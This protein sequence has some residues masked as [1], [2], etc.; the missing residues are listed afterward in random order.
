MNL[1]LFTFLLRRPFFK[2]Q[3]RIFNYLFKKG[4]LESF[5]NRI[6]KPLVGNFKIKC[7]TKTW[8]GAQIIYLGE[9]EDYIKKTFAT[10]IKQEDI[11]LD[12][13]ANIGFHTLYFASLVGENGKVIA[14]EPI[15]S[16]FA[17][18]EENV[19]LNN[20][21]NIVL[22]NLALGNENAT[23][24]INIEENN[25]NPG[26]NNLFNE[27][28]TLVH[29]KIGDDIV[30][31]EKVNFIKIDVEGYELLALKGLSEL[32]RKQKP[33]IIFEYD[34]NYQLKTSNNPLDIFSFIESFEYTFH[35][36]ERSGIKGIKNLSELTSADILALPIK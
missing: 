32:I 22:H 35:T 1:N 16:T 13:G 6:V 21:N 31:D 24:G 26:A 29:C 12:I 36:I 18:L 15:P 7:N 9:Y 23:L 19:G 8:I 20:F 14:F 5:E 2:G 30:V 3:H 28:N 4:Y 34:K 17:L 11:V 33:T 10:Y 25:I 27:G